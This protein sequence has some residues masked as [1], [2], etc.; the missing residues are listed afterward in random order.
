[1]WAIAW[2]SRVDYQH[3]RQIACAGRITFRRFLFG[4]PSDKTRNYGRFC[5]DL[6]TLEE[7]MF[8]VGERNTLYAEVKDLRL[9]IDET[10]S[11]Q[12]L[13][14]GAHYD[15]YNPK[16]LQLTFAPAHPSTYECSAAL[17]RFE[18]EFS[19]NEA[20][21]LLESKGYRKCTV[22]EL[23]AYGA[24]YPER[25]FP[26]GVRDLSIQGSNGYSQRL[27]LDRTTMKSAPARRLQL[28]GTPQGLRAQVNYRDRVLAI[29][30]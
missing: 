9:D 27:V 26:I 25:Q 17:F 11:I 4:K 13:I 18:G 14:E 23:L 22:Y 10:L 19:I 29:R 28:F 24:Q 16:I 21:Y 20:S 15:W 30:L 8:G 5:L 1:M 2:L 7:N 3:T 12:E 6:V